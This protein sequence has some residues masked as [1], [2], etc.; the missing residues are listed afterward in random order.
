[1]RR[2]RRLAWVA[3]FWAAPLTAGVTVTPDAARTGTYGLRATVEPSCTGEENVLVLG[4][5]IGPEQ[6]EACKEVVVGAQVQA[7]GDLVV[8]AGERVAFGDGFSVATGGHMAAG[9]TGA[10]H[11]SYVVDETPEAE[12]EL[13]VRWYVRLDAVGLAPG[14]EITLLR[15]VGS[16]GEDRGW[17][18]YQAGVAGGS[19]CAEVLDDDGDR[20]TTEPLTIGAAWHRLELAWQAGSALSPTGAVGLQVDGGPA[21]T[22][23]GLPLS[24]ALVDAVELGVVEAGTSDGWL[25]VDDYATARGGPIGGR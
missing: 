1:M 10:W 8:E 11:P 6:V 13:H 22:A 19:V 20:H 7:G 14:D 12:S 16:G 17:V 25:D 2:T 21:S 18:R 4:P 15:I 24:G 9:T 3:L 23:S 5:V